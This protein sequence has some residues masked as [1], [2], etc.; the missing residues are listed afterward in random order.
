MGSWRAVFWGLLAVSA[1]QAAALLAFVPADPP[2]RDR[3]PLNLAGS[4]LFTVAVM[5]VVVATTVLGES[6]NRITG[7]MLLAAA[8]LVAGLFLAADRRSAAPLLPSALLRR[9]LVLRG[10]IGS[11]LNTATTTSVATLVTLYL[12][13]ALGRTP[14][15]AAATFLPLS[16]LVIIGSAAATKLMLRLARELIAAIGLGVIGIG[17]AL[18]L[19]N[20]TSGLL[21]GAGLAVTGLGLGLASVVATSM[22]TDVPEDARATASGIVNTSAQLGTVI[23]TATI[24]LLAAGTTG[25]PGH[26]TGTPYVAWGAAA[27]LAGIA[28]IAFA[29][30]RVRP[31]AV[32]DPQR[33]VV[34][35]ST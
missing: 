27:G 28:A 15:Q 19:L 1:I 5:L 18:P 8:G 31:A 25:F 21:V 7:A 2:R 24:L 12:Q 13:D 33:T 29:R 30:F 3:T 14:L 4:G 11:F 32:A 26:T 20:A 9:P 17:I 35:D 10:T 22:A 16:V 6:A 23:G 34:A